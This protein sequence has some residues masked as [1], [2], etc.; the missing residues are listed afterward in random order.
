MDIKNHPQYSPYC[1]NFESHAGQKSNYVKNNKE[2]E[3]IYKVG[4]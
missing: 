1:L 3:I 2:R 4:F